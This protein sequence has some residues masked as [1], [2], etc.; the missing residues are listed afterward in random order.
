MTTESDDEL[1]ARYRTVK[2]DHEKAVKS[3]NKMKPGSGA[4]LNKA[5]WVGSLYFLLLGM[6]SE[7]E[8]RGIKLKHPCT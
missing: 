4:R 6:E 2:A 1:L 8:R 5:R 3:M 7:A